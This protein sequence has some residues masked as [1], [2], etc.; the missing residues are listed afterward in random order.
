MTPLEK[1]KN[2]YF[3]I[4]KQLFHSKLIAVTKK[5]D[6][7]DIKFLYELGQRDFGENKVLELEEKAIRLNLI[8]PEI[9]WHFI[10]NLQSNKLNRLL[11]IPHLWAIHSISSENLYAKLCRHNSLPNLFLEVNTAK[12]PQKEG[13]KDE[14]E[15][16]DC[17]KKYPQINPMGLMTLGKIGDEA[18][19][20]QRLIEIRNHLNVDWKLS[21]GM[22][23]SYLEAQK[24]GSDWVRVGSALFSLDK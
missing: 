7:E 18:K 16:R 10:G 11:K 17:L 6:L 1:I 4:K 22:S 5:R 15:I 8:C 20:F 23:D 21:M 9:R 13:F 12:E 2:N 14:S 3:F 19:C 24:L